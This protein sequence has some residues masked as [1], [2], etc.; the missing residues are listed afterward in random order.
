MSLLAGRLAYVTRRNVRNMNVSRGISCAA[1]IAL[2]GVLAGCSHLPR[3]HWRGPGHK[4]APPPPEVHE[5]TIS[6]RRRG[7]TAFPQYW[8]RN[9]LLV[10]LQSGE[11]HGR[12][13]PEARAGNHVA[14]Q[15][16]VQGHARAV[17]RAGGS[18]E[19]A[20]RLPI[21]AQGA[22]PIDLE[23]SPDIYTPRTPQLTVTWGPGSG[24]R[25]LS[26]RSVALQAADSRC[27]EWRS[28][29]GPCPDRRR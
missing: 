16:C 6:R 29:H 19:R 11:R 20:L 28:A 17:R 25:R 15:D 4:A 5:L 10:D 24:A 18:G 26:A 2:L 14:G 8:K 7:T 23:L 27:R 12:H 3:P 1:A 13:R 9:T 21:T 22:K